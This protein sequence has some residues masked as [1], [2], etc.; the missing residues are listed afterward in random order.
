MNTNTAQ[1]YINSL[2]ENGRFLRDGEFLQEGDLCLDFDYCWPTMDPGA[3]VV[4]SQ[5]DRYYRLNVKKTE[6]TKQA[7][8]YQ[9]LGPYDIIQKGDQMYSKVTRGWGYVKRS[10]GKNLAYWQDN[11]EPDVTRIRRPIK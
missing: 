8:K 5:G 6:K 1:K 2:L 11:E 3:K 4:S 7:K 10:I 9:Y